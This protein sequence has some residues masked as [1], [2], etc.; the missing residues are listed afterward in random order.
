MKSIPPMKELFEMAGM[1]LP[2]YLGKSIEEP[3]AEVKAEPQVKEEPKVK[4]EPKK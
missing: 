2:K 4:A 3:I 1:E